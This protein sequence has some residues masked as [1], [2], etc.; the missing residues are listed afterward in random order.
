MYQ[1][2]FELVLGMSTNGLQMVEEIFERMMPVVPA[3][4][5]IV[6]IQSKRY[7]VVSVEWVF[8]EDETTNEQTVRIGLKAI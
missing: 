1:V 3:L 6:T 5:H 2:I 7:R 8:Y 4:E